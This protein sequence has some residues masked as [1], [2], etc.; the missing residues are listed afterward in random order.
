MT[1]GIIRGCSTGLGRSLAEAAL[2]VTDK[3]RWLGLL[4]RCRT[5]SAPST[6]S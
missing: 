5:T 3:G 1:T 6:F 2:D 4:L